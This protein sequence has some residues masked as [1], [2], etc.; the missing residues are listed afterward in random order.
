MR[1]LRTKWF[2]SP[3]TMMGR[4]CSACQHAVAPTDIKAAYERVVVEDEWVEVLW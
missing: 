3:K 2:W 4:N 1:M